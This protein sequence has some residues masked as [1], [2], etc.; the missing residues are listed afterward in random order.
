MPYIKDNNKTLK[1]GSPIKE[2][3]QL[4]KLEERE[5]ILAGDGGRENLEARGFLA[6]V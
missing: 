2:T 5:M 4:E 3:K 1:L 6:K